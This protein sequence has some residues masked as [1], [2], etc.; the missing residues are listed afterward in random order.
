MPTKSALALAGFLGMVVGCT[1]DGMAIGRSQG[2]IVGGSTTTADEAVVALIMGS[3]DE[4][5]GLC[6][7]TLIA[8]RVG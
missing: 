5:Q 1:D 3:G 6:S 8:K 7:G 4:I 2:E